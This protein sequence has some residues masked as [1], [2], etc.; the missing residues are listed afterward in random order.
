MANSRLW[1]SHYAGETITKDST[2]S[3]GPMPVFTVLLVFSKIAQILHNDQ[4]TQKRGLRK[5]CPGTS[6]VL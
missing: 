1:R 2:F 3:T 5:N 6:R 4:G